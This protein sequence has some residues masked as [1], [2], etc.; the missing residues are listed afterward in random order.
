MAL[1]ADK[2]AP[3]ALD[4]YIEE[5]TQRGMLSQSGPGSL[6]VAGARL[7]DMGRDLR[8]VQIDDLVTVVVSDRASAVAKGTTTSS[9]KS[10]VDS[11]IGKLAGPL[12]ATGPWPNLAQLDSSQSL[13]GQGETSRESSLTTTL[14]ARVTHVLP[15]GFLVLEGAKDVLVNSERQQV[16]L[17]GVIRWNDVGPANT[18]RSDRLANLEIHVNGKGVVGDAIRRPHFLYRLLLG[19]LPF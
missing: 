5:A 12:R 16:T 14:T 18:V 6:Y 17:R 13:D 10:S 2:V 15:N 19:L 11:S 1:A 9:R 3:S 8:A 7:S 4:R